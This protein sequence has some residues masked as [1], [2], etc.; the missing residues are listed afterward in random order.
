MAREEALYL[1]NGRPNMIVFHYD[2]VRYKLHHRGNRAD[3]ISLPAEA[4]ND[5]EISKWIR[6]GQLEKISKEAFM[7]LGARQVDILPNQFLKRDMRKH[8]GA[9]VTMRPAEADT[10]KSLTQL[11]EK[12]V[13]KQIVEK[14]SLEWAGDLMSTDE[15]LETMDYSDD[16]M[17]YPSKHRDEDARREMGY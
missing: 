5:P 17:N 7:K 16:S 3:S 14:S 15:E 11:D 6:K 12:D 4:K 13:H 8:R 9:E 10:T 1:R 2:G